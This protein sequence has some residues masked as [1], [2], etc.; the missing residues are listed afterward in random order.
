M[1]R[2]LDLCGHCVAKLGTAYSVQ[3]APGDFDHKVKCAECGKSRYGG[4]YKVEM[5]RKGEGKTV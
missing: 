5:K 2:T 4:I 3:R 1:K